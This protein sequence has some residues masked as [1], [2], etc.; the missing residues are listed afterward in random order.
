MPFKIIKNDL[1]TLEVDA[2]VN[3]T[4]IF[5]SGG[6]GV[7]EKIHLAAG[8]ELREEFNLDSYVLNAPRK[9]LHSLLGRYAVEKDLAIE[10]ED[11]VSAIEY[12]T[13]GKENMTDLQKVLFI[14]D[15]C[16]EG[17]VGNTFDNARDLAF[18]NLDKCVYYILDS[19]MKFVLE[20]GFSVE[21]NAQNA[22]KYYRKY[23]NLYTDNK[24]DN[25]LEC[26]NRNLVHNVVIYDLK[27]RNPLYDY[28]I[29]STAN[30]N[31]QMEACVSYL[32]QDFDIK[33]AELAEGWT[34]IDLGDIIVHV[35]SNDDR[36]KY[37]LDKLYSALPIVENKIIK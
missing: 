6:G 18:V 4:D 15:F 22:Y 10:D 20:R 28:V 37:G 36:E 13:T 14:S 8:K 17:R 26:I 21:E 30:S 31:R 33:G 19:K 3:P 5:F 24:L 2:I 35:F 1:T 23:K 27:D 9:I 16:E 12:H 29:I 11:I 7:D 32:R 25:V 34:L